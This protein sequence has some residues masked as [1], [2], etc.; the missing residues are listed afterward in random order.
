MKRPEKKYILRV[1][2]YVSVQSSSIAR[3]DFF[4]LK[5]KC[6]ET[7]FEIIHRQTHCIYSGGLRWASGVFYTHKS[8]ISTCLIQLKIQNIYP[9]WYVNCMDSFLIGQKLDPYIFIGL[10]RSFVLWLNIL[11]RKVKKCIYSN[12][13]W[14]LC[15]M[16]TVS[17]PLV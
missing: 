10:S 17:Y 6:H 12:S 13:G 3:L 4:M 11:W 16:D 14:T 8:G 1:K 7:V 9:T 2:R 5:R 15:L